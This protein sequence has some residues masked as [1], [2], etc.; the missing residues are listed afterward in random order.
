MKKLSTFKN[1][2]YVRISNIFDAD[3]LSFPGRKKNRFWAKW[4]SFAYLITR[5]Y[6]SSPQ[7]FFFSTRYIFISRQEISIWSRKHI[8]CDAP[9]NNGREMKER[10]KKNSKLNRFDEQKNIPDIIAARARSRISRGCWHLKRWTIQFH[11]MPHLQINCSP[12]H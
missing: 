5:Y 6:F 3:D 8:K 2:K 7:D 11:S 12:F 9:S 10:W 4:F 1:V